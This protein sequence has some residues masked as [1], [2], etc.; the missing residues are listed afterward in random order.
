MR[1]FRQGN[2]LIYGHIQ[3][4]H[5]ASPSGKLTDTVLGG[6][7]CMLTTFLCSHSRA[8]EPLSSLLVCVCDW[9]QIAAGPDAAG[10]VA[11]AQALCE[12]VCVCVCACV[13]VCE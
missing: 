9:P 4:K 10:E 8:H 6:L 7:C 2:H 13:C 3:S 5:T 11:Q 1:C 12:Q